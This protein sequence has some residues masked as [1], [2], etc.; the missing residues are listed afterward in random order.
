[1]NT[2]II[3]GS[4]RGKA[5]NTEL[6]IRQFIA[7]MS[8]PPEVGYAAG[9]DPSELAENAAGYTTLLVFMPLYVHAMPGIVLKFFEKLKPAAPG[10]RMGFVVQAGFIEGA[11][12]RF[13]KRYCGLLAERLGYDYLGMVTKGDAAGVSMLPDFFS[14]KL[15]RLLNT[16]GRRYEETGRFDEAAA[17]ELAGTYQLSKNEA[18]LYGFLAG[19]GVSHI[20]WKKFWRDN[21]VSGRG[22]DRPF[23]A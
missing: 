17:A 1:M 2:F 15:F 13:L 9:A 19:I 14:R 10:Q 7:G 23:L 22:M 18:R 20:F 8:T 21:G 12:A 3:N 5:G 16:L 4:P 11:Q 6:F